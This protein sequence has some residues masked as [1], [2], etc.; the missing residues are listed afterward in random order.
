MQASVHH[1]D[2]M[3]RI[4]TT[5]TMLSMVLCPTQLIFAFCL[6]CEAVGY[7]GLIRYSI[8]GVS[9]A[10]LYAFIGFPLVTFA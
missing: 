7:G 8:I 3:N 5:L 9:N 4:D 10:V 1:A 6:T 2:R